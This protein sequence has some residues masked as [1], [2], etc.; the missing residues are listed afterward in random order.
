M[1]L[2]RG[3]RKKWLQS[4]LMLFILAIYV[5]AGMLLTGKHF[6]HCPLR[7]LM[8]DFFFNKNLVCFVASGRR[9]FGEFSVY[10]PTKKVSTG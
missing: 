9:D 7:D 4:L 6:C 1:L 8:F 3:K 2:R 5:V 10:N